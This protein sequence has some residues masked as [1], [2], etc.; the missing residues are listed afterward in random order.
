MG[1]PESESRA[2]LQRIAEAAGRPDVDHRWRRHDLL[3]W[4]NRAVVHRATAYD[5]TEARLLWRV[6]VRLEG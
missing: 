6:S 5:R 1:L 2:I 3:V 4:D